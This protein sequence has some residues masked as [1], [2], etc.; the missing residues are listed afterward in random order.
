MST[1]S[2][3][4]GSLVK[5]SILALTTWIVSSNLFALIICLAWLAMSENSTAYTYFAPALAQN[6]DKMPVPHPTS[7]TTLSLNKCAF[8]RIESRY[9]SVRALS[10]IMSSWMPKCAYEL[11]Y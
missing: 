5:S 9:A 7:M 4:P 3:L 1:L 2:Y 6:I 10:L 11:K 8:L